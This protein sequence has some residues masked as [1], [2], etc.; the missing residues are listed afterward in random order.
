MRRSMVLN[1]VSF[2]KIKYILFQYRFNM[3]AMCILWDVFYHYKRKTITEIPT[4]CALYAHFL[5]TC[6]RASNRRQIIFR[7]DKKKDLKF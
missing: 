2:Q 6:T 1:C 7:F 3:H 4:S 5:C